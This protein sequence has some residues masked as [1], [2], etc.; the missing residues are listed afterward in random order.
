MSYTLEICAGSVQSAVAAQAGGAHRL[1]LCQNLEQGGITPSFGLVQ[2]VLSLVS[3]PVFV[4]I[5][6]RPGNFCYSPDELAIMVTDIAQCRELGCAG[7][8]LGVLDAQGRVDLPRCRALLKAA[9]PLPVT[10]HRAFDACPDQAQALEDVVALGCQRILTSG[11]QATAEAGQ[12]Q[13]AALVRQAA[14]RICIMPGAGIRPSNI[15]AL[16]TRTAA[17]E[18]HASASHLLPAAPAPRPTEF[19]AALL[20]TDATTVAALLAELTR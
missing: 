2:R 20:E 14:G 19:D 15:W 5:R 16:A 7:V 9:G 17:T 12:A 13:L 1:E 10:F 8:V 18:F 3:I 11:G 4:L 6:P